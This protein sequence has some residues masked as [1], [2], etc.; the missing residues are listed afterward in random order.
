MTKLGFQDNERCFVGTVHSFALSQVIAPYAR[1]IDGLL[2]Q[3]YRVATDRDIRAAV[4]I[5][6][7]TVFGD[8]ANPNDRW[9]LAKEKRLRNVDR[10]LSA[11]RGESP[12]LADL[13]ESYESQLRRMKLIDFDDMPLIAFRMIKE[14]PWIRNA[15]RARFPVLFVDEY[16]DLG[17]ALN[18]LVWLLCFEGGVRLF[19]VGDVDQSIYAFAGANPVLLQQVSERDDTK[20]IRLRFNY[21]SGARII[22]ASLGALGEERDYQ[23]C[24]GAV[25]GVLTF[26]PV[27]GGLEVQAKYLAE[28]VLPALLDRGIPAEQIAILYRAA[29]LGDIVAGAL[30]S[31]DITCVRTD[32]N[33]LVRRNSRLARFIEDCASWITGG[34]RESGSPYSRLLWQALRLVYGGRTSDIERQAIS[35]QLIAFLRSSGGVHTSTNAW[36]N[37][38]NAELIR[39]WRDIARNT[40][41][42][43]DVCAD[44]I[45][46]TDPSKGFDMPLFVF[47]GRMEGSGRVV[48]STLHSAKGREFDAV[49]IFGANNGGL[50][51]S[52][53]K[54]SGTA[55]REARRLFYVG[56][57]RPKKELCL[58]YQKGNHSPWIAELYHRSQ[59]E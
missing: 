33:A 34:W 47:S 9:S 58:I 45:A 8:S 26:W 31:L 38:F 59:R 16:Q 29:W 2:P 48:L 1:C 17:H 30:A 22:R 57:T 6:H 36:L 21:R 18:E 27:E 51:S 3:D 13:I 20:T 19:A 10:S 46:R 54:R 32:G 49:I 12:E 23:S 5:A 39:P 53:D 55:L 11:W 50:P 42:E 37:H 56:V 41:Q 52:R 14:H 43:W 44:M 15:L 4:Q 40:H 28:T 35:T 24:D 7:D 25:D